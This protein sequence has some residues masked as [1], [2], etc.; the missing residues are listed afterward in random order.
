MFSEVF[1]CLRG[2]GG[3]GGALHT[4]GVCIHG[5]VC[6]Q[7]RVFIQVDLH[8]GGSAFGGRGGLYPGDSASTGRGL[9]PGKGLHPGRGLDPGWAEPPPS[10]SDTMGYGQRAGGT[11]PTGM[12]SCLAKFFSWKWKKLDRV[13]RAS[14]AFIDRK[15]LWDHYKDFSSL[16]SRLR[17]SALANEGAGR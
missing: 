1:V 3:G 15:V 9:H 6:I 11:H 13:G 2:G 5:V 16:G 14:L 10:Q 17:L 4:G 12:H 8:P 7:G